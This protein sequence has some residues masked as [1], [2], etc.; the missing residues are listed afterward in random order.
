METPD[1]VESATK[2]SFGTTIDQHLTN[3]SIEIRDCAA[4]GPI[5]LRVFC[6]SREVQVRLNP[7]RGKALDFEFVYEGS[8][9]ATIQR[10]ERATTSAYLTENPP[11]VWFADG[12]KLEGNLH[13]ELCT[14]AQLYSRDRFEALD[15]SGIDITKGVTTRGSGRSNSVQYR[16]IEHIQGAEQHEIFDR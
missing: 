15:W 11:T 3:C 7:T 4:T 14:A 2:I 10:G 5:I 8:A 16:T 9:K 1:H 6:E 13:V 12:S